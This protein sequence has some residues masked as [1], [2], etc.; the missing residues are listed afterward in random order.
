MAL[1][2]SCIH[3]ARQMYHH[4][5][6]LVFT[7]ST[8]LFPPSAKH[9]LGQRWTLGESPMILLDA[10]LLE[11]RFILLMFFFFFF[12]FF[13]LYLRTLLNQLTNC[14]TNISL[15]SVSDCYRWILVCGEG[16]RITSIVTCRASGCLSVSKK[17][18]SLPFICLFH[19]N[20]GLKKQMFMLLGW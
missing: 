10:V 11:C 20:W 19:S 4:I 6:R 18:M 2:R 7:P 14:K 3:P 12:F 8:L 16:C 5:S 17:F 9:Y 15:L 1:C 13:N